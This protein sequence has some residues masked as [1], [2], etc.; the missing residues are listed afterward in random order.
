[1][2][3][4]P[5]TFAVRLKATVTI[6]PASVTLSWANDSNTT[7]THLVYKRTPGTT[8]WSQL[9]AT[10]APGISQYTDVNVNAGNTYEYYVQRRD[11]GN[12]VAHGYLQAGIDFEPSLSQSNVLL[13][14]DNNYAQPLATEITQLQTDLT[15]EGWK[16]HTRYVNRNQTVASVK[17]LIRNLR[18]TTNLHAV[19]LLGH[20]AVPYSGGFKAVQGNPFPPDGHAE[21]GGA[22]PADV[23]YGCFTESIWTDE[24]VNDTTPARI[25]NRNI[26]GDG[27]FD[28]VNIFN[29]DES[30]LQIGRVDFTQLPL[31]GNDTL[32]TQQYL[33]K[34]HAYK[35]GAIR[36][37][38]KGIIDDNLGKLGNE[39]FTPATWSSFSAMFGD[40]ITE[41]DY[42]TEAKKWPY[43]FSH[44]CGFGSYTSAN[45]IANSAQFSSDSIQ[46]G[47]T[48]LFGSYFGDWDSENNLLRAALTSPNGGLASAWSGRPYWHVHPMAMGA[49]IG[50][51]AKAIQNNVQYNDNTTIVGMVSNF[52]PTSIHIALMGD[53]TLRLHPRQASMN[54]TARTNNDSTQNLVTW[55]NVPG[56]TG[57]LLRKESLSYLL[58]PVDTSWVDMLSPSRYITYTVQPIWREITPSGTYFNYGMGGFDSA[59][60]QNSTTSIETINQS[61][62]QLKAYPNPASTDVTI[63]GE[64]SLGT[65]TVWDVWGKALLQTSTNE[66]SAHLN[67][68]GFASGIYIVKAVN[69]NKQS[70]MKI[71]VN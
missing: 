16:V 41:G 54:V 48:F 66:T 10:L 57:Y 39:V 51:C 3:Q 32:L 28:I 52:S 6:Q 68:S 69:G 7:G 36:L 63:S 70:T 27:K 29:N 65:V 1:M 4:L 17:S 55:N 23:Y 19:Y 42:L 8:A 62:A 33:Q 61:F 11:T 40:S 25:Q 47:F 56:V 38:Q 53:P 14:I 21:H 59:Y 64:T 15:S 37:Q 9:L 58:T 49:T 24:F 5:K 43:A 18:E 44:G 2:G 45:G 20:V 60:A 35:T 26:P 34:V 67:L 13:L 22:W 50:S 30:V 46:H 31:L 12:K 71:R